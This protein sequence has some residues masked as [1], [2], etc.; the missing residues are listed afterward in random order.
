MKKSFVSIG[1]SVNPATTNLDSLKKR[2]AAV[3]ESIVAP[4]GIEFGSFQHAG[5]TYALSARL[6]VEVDLLE[7]RVPPVVV[8]ER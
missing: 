7:S 6:V 4:K 1:R 5:R 3:A 8:R 2:A